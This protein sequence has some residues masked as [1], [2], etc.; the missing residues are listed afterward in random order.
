MTNRL[1]LISYIEGSQDITLYHTGLLPPDSESNRL[2]QNASFW[3]SDSA[4]DYV[5]DTRMQED[6]ASIC[7]RVF[8][9]MMMVLL[10]SAKFFLVLMTICS[11][12]MILTFLNWLPL[13][14]SQMLYLTLFSTALEIYFENRKSQPSVS[15]ALKVLWWTIVWLS[16][17][18]DLVCHFL[19][20]PDGLCDRDMQLSK[21]S[22][23]TLYLI[24][25][26]S[27]FRFVRLEMT[28]SCW[29]SCT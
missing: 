8:F 19:T 13:W 15:E 11:E 25:L 21:T 7:K 10:N 22:M 2:R 12:R 1:Y 6:S 24:C 9:E 26:G 4:I 23:D 16:Y 3:F 29:F 5:F 20:R 18:Y 17:P 27:R 28:K 14:Q